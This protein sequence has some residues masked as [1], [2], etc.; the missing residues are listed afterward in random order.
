MTCLV[1]IHD[2]LERDDDARV[3]R[4]PAAAAAR[5]R[6][7][8]GYVDVAP[9]AAAGRPAGADRGDPEAGYEECTVALEPGA[10]LLHVHRRAGGGPR[11]PGRRGPGAARRR[12]R[13]A[14][15]GRRREVCEAA[16]RLMGRDASHDD[17][18][19]VLAMRARRCCPPTRGGR[20]RLPRA[21]RGRLEDS[22][23]RPADD[24]GGSGARPAPSS[25]TCSSA[26][27]MPDLVDTASLLVSELVTNALRHGGGPRELLVAVDGRGRRCRRPGRLAAAAAP[28]GPGTGPAR[29]GWT[30]AACPRTAAGCC[31][32]SG[33]RTAGAGGPSTA[34]S[35]SG[36]GW[37]AAT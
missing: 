33:S 29:P 11:H 32:S 27:A 20:T 2:A 5:R 25:P 1:G 6:R 24:A 18:T 31:S 12:L 30:A 17:D 14:R 22:A 9:R 13:R 34:A 4:A 3:G 37:S 21:G 10:T 35:S 23:G 36:S 7:R 26:P 15:A 19:A 16:L 8:R 28:G